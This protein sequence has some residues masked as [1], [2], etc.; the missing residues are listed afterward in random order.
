MLGLVAGVEDGNEELEMDQ[1]GRKETLDVVKIEAKVTCVSDDSAM[2]V[3][4]VVMV[5]V[6]TVAE[7]SA[8]SVDEVSIEGYVDVSVDVSGISLRIS[9]SIEV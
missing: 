9:D 5:E 2:V 1:L 3:D 7:N 6:A 8:S 4:S